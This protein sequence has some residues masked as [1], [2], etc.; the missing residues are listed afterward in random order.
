VSSLDEVTD[1]LLIGRAMMMAANVARRRDRPPRL[2]Q[3][4]TPTRV[5]ATVFHLHVHLLGGR[6]H[7]RRLDDMKAT[8]G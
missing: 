4:S 3:M 8:S 2:S 1:P 5:L 6:S 7:D